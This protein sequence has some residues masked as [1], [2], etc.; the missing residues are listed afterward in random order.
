[1]ISILII[2]VSLALDALSVSVAGGIKMQKART[3]DALKIAAFFGVFQGG[4]PLL[5]WLIGR[6]FS[7][8]ITEY[9]N[10]VAFVLLT[11]IGLK[12]IQE[13][14]KDTSE[15]ESINI[16]SNKTLF[17][18]AVATSIDALIVG[19]TL[20]Y[21]DLPLLAS[22]LV[23]GIVTFILSFLGFIFGKKLGTFF[24]GKVEIIGGLALIAIGVKLLL[25]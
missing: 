23:I 20:A 16:L 1:M 3:N 24:E 21:I 4:M 2:A 17:A 19:I 8:V 22:S 10:W 5:G 12:M 15:K 11:A 25:T 9:S 18:L 6:S 7:G 13:A 14:L